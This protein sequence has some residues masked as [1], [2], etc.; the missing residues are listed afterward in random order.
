MATVIGTTGDSPSET[1]ARPRSRLMRLLR[2]STY[3]LAGLVLFIFLVNLLWKA[4]GDNQWHLEFERNGVQVYSL[5]EPGTYNKRFR[6][7][8]RTDYTLTH[9]VAG[10][11]E[12]ATL[13]NC[14]NSIPDCVDLKVI[15]PWDS[16]TMSDTVLWK[17]GLPA[18]FT[19][20]EIVIRSQVSQDPVSRA[21][22]IDVIAAPNSA[23]R[24]PDAIR[25]TH[26]Q[27]RWIYT[28]KENGQV[29][30]EFIQD[31]D[32]GGTFPRFLLNLAGAE[33]VYKFIHDQLP[34]LLDKTELRGVRYDFIK[35][36]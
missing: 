22:T 6:A 19:A 3:L 33:E 28:P 24:N 29:E 21:V 15:S 17:L 34:Q 16:K 4:S 23:P 35:E 11:I 13:D 31:M 1:I 9:L 25:L 12:N 5:K 2:L 30:I 27:N 7:L 20:R 36:A 14:L 10:L 8:T 26:V 32:M 18:P